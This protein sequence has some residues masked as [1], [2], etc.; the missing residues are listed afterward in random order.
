MDNK[1]TEAIYNQAFNGLSFFYRDTDLSEKLI[2]K[3]KVGQILKE[4]GFTDMSYKAGGLVSSLRYL[5]ASAN[6]RDVSSV[7]PDGAKFGHV[8]LKSNAFFKV[9]DIYT[10]GDRT[11]IFLLEIPETAVE[12]FSATTSNIENDIIKKARE[13][14]ETNIRILPVA[15][16]QSEAWKEG[17]E[18][19]IGMSTKGVFFL[20][21][22]NNT[23][24]ATKPWWK[25]W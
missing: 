17:T 19:P 2:S 22:D 9:L 13:N 1:E 8:I 4:R 24:T 18:F 15:V 23:G 5:I 10:I 20:D 14:F 12:L 7:N 6:A 11:Q 25:F 16:L 3:Y 21:E